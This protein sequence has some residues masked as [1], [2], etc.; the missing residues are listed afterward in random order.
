MRKTLEKKILEIMSTKRKNLKED[1]SGN[2]QG[3]A[4]K[5]AWDDLGPAI[6]DPKGTLPDY[7]KSIKPG[8]ASLP[9]QP[10]ACGPESCQDDTI[11]FK[12]A[13]LKETE[14]KDEDDEDDK[15]EDPDD[16]DEK[17]KEVKEDLTA[18]QE[19]ARQKSKLGLGEP[20]GKLNDKKKKD[21]DEEED[22]DGDDGVDK[23][24]V[25]EDINA[26]FVGENISEAFKQKVALIYEASVNLR[27][28]ALVEKRISELEE[29]YTQTFETGMND[30]RE[31][32]TTKVDSYLNF[33]VEQWMEENKLAIEM[34]LRTE[35]VEEFMSKLKNLF[36]EHYIEIPEDKVDVLGGLAERVQELQDKL[37]EQITANIAL[38]EEVDIHG[39]EKIL[40]EASIGLST[41]QADKLKQLAEGL[42]FKG[43]DNYRESLKTLRE[44]YH[45]KPAK[46]AINLTEEKDPK[47]IPPIGEMSSIM[48][49]LRLSSK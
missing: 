19:N 22:E 4:V 9:A 32:L 18:D 41:S 44:S 49:A 36:N 15:D 33:V 24:E 11:P 6:I 12:P 3:D 16:K 28:K 2:P 35:L 27:V 21:E 43:T 37:D 29:Y 13:D 45:V 46:G 1:V 40:R 39:K 38:K 26:L 34:G 17:A 7:G 5:P 10:V 20:M 8:Q 23:K 14:D 25:K 30:I 31:S 47:G 42:E 48:N